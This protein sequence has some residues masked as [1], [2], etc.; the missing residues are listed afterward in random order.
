VDIV[1]VAQRLD[2]TAAKQDVNVARP[3]MIEYPAT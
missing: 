3:P 2:V 1:G